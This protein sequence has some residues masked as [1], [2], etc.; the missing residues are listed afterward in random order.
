MIEKKYSGLQIP[1][2][3]IISIEEVQVWKAIE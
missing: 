3:Q 1:S 2:K